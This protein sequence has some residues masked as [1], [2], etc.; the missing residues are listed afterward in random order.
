MKQKVLIF[1]LDSVG[2]AERMTTLIGKELIA[3]SYDVTFC[4]I[5]RTTQSSITDFI[6]KQINKEYIYSK[7]GLRCLLSMLKVISKERPSYV[8]SSIY[9]LN[10]K[11]LLIRFLFPK[12]KF[13]IRCDNYLYTYSSKQ[14]RLLSV[15]YSKADIIIAQTEEMRDELV[16]QVGIDFS[17]V[18]VLHN[19]I[20]TKTIQDKL[21]ESTNP[22]PN[23]GKKHV[24]AVGR[25]SYQKG[26]DMLIDA[27]VKIRKQHSNIDLYIVGDYTIMDE[28]IYKE[29]TSKIVKE[30][31]QHD[32]HCVGYKDNPYTYIKY[33]NCFV[34]SSR[35]E[36]LPNALIESLYLG[37]P[38]AAFKCIPIIERIVNDG[39][40]GCLAEKDDINSLS[41]AILGALKMDR[42]KMSYYPTDISRFVEL[43]NFKVGKSRQ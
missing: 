42:I 32:L 33:A 28:I 26:F 18:F 21:S 14:R 20:D 10:T 40:D 9:S 4:L 27:F 25:F 22:Y 5:K 15:T 43:F 38:V 34:L 39:V 11:L 8:F 16:A 1:V 3:Q 13:I 36:G 37:T 24:V 12:T 19:P 2:G 7:N 30:G 35:W 23:N 17:K 41:G 6:P 31:L 29:L